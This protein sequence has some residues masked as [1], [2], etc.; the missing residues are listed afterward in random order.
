MEEKHFRDKSDEQR[1]KYT[2]TFARVKEE[3]I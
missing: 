2:G 3:S 1:G